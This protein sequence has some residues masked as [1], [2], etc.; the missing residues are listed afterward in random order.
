MTTLNL[1]LGAIIGI[2]TLVCFLWKRYGS[3]DAE[4]RKLKKESRRL[5]REM[6]IALRKGHHDKY[7]SFH[8]KRM[9][10]SR[11]ISTLRKR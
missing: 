6:R 4:L 11:Q 1:I 9:C 5:R 2:T 3:T 7:H 8:I 10:V